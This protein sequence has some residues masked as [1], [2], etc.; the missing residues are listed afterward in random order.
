MAAKLASKR[1]SQ[2]TLFFSVTMMPFEVTE[3]LENNPGYVEY[4]GSEENNRWVS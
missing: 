3:R 2:F 1:K 4:L